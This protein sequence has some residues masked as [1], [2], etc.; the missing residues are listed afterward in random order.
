MKSPT[1]LQK[2]AF[3]LG[4]KKALNFCRGEMREMA[5]NFDQKLAGL[6]A[7]YERAIRAMR[8][9]QNRYN[10]LMLR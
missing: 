3:L 2:R 7:D 1:D 10:P 5:K 9:E 6:S 8:S 4:Y